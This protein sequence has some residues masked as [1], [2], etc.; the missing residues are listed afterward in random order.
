M[1][2]RIITDWKQLPIMTQAIA[3]VGKIKFTLSLNFLYNFPN[4]IFPKILAKRDD[5]TIKLK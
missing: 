2:L 3:I 4:M 5:T 1:N